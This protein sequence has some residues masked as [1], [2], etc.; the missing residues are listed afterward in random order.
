MPVL[1]FQFLSKRNYAKEA[2][3][4]QPAYPAE[5]EITTIEDAVYIVVKND[6]SFLIDNVMN[7]YEAQSGGEERDFDRI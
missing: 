6:V 7:F 2:Q 1:S 5:L 3:E 4:E